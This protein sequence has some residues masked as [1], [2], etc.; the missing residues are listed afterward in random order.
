[1][2]PVKLGETMESAPAFFIFSALRISLQRATTRT[3]GASC[4]AVSAIIRLRLSSPVMAKTPLAS[5]DIR[6]EQDVVVDR[7]AVDVEHARLF[8]GIRFQQFELFIDGDVMAVGGLEFLADV[9]ADPA[10]ATE[11]VMPMHLFHHL[12]HAPSPH[13]FVEIAGQNDGRHT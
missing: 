3:P 4:L 12:V 9:A 2:P 6:F 13:R 5:L 1:M 8:L 10:E 11:N 7:V